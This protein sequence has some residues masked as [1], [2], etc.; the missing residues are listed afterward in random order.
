M[1]P[2]SRL[3]HPV[4]YVAEILSISEPTIRRYIQNGTIRVVHFG[5]RRLIHADEL[6][7]LARDGFTKSV[8]G[9][10]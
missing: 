3:L 6:A 7:R 4:P 10:E 5:S 9:A 2:S 8:T 1:A